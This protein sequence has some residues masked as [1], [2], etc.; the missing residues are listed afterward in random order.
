ML[1]CDVLLLKLALSK[2]DHF[3]LSFS[4]QPGLGKLTII[5][6]KLL[7]KVVLLKHLTAKLDLTTINVQN[8][9]ISSY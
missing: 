9:V 7:S 6:M 3:Q 5:N 1:L 2:N 4:F 8:F